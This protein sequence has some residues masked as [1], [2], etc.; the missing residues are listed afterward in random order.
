MT[1]ETFVEFT[2]EAAHSLPPF[3]ALHGHSLKVTLYLQGVPDPTYGWSHNL[4]DIESIIH[5]V[6][7]EVDHT[8]LND[9]IPNPSL[10]NVAQWLWRRFDNRLAGL[11]RLVLSRG[12]DGSAEGCTCSRQTAAQSALAA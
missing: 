12:R 8:Y 4:Y 10:E 7:R 3:A 2:F 1:I 6:K 9:F 11:D 5:D